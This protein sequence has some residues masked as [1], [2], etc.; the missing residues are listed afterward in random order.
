MIE[1]PP[2]LIRLAPKIFVGALLFI[3]LVLAWR[4]GDL[5]G[6][7]DFKR[8]F[9]WR[10]YL[11]L[12]LGFPLAVILFMPL[13]ITLRAL[14]PNLAGMKWVT[15]FGSF[16]GDNFKYWFIVIGIH[17]A[18]VIFKKEDWARKFF[19][20]VLSGAVTGLA[21]H[22]LKFV[23]LRARPYTG[24][25]PFVFF[26][27]AGYAAD[28]RGFQS[29]PSGDVGLVAGAATYLFYSTRHPLRWL[30]FLLPLST[31]LARVYLDRHWFS[32][33]VGSFCLSLILGRL[34]WDYLGTEK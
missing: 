15:E 7:K 34:V 1:I 21:V 2:K 23:F 10:R 29:F 6:F 20:A 30:F 27:Q 19:G 25:T 14:I 24:L 13:D 12:L 9:S 4:R 22:L 8:N 26:D 11:I 32:D 18:F 31:A 5:K 28:H 33:T 3:T 16:I 17:L